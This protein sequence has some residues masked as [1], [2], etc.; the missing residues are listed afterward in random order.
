MVRCTPA[1]VMARASISPTTGKT[2]SPLTR[3]AIPLAAVGATLTPPTAEGGALRSQDLRTSGD[4]VTLD[5]TII[6]VD[7]ATGAGL[8]D[9]PLAT[10]PM[11]M[12]GASSRTA[13]AIRSASP[14]AP[15]PTS[16][17]SATSAG[18]NGKRSIGSKTHWTRGGELRLAVL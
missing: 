13:C 12:R 15:A 5:G 9:N 10:I 17:G 1:A 18:T 7:P 3:A 8:S 6:R 2:D 11:P 4:P 14:P 16:S